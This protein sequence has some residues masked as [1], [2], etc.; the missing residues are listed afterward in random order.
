M[1]K[2][3]AFLATFAVLVFARFAVAQ[4]AAGNWYAETLDALVRINAT[5][6][7]EFDANWQR[8]VD[9]LETPARV[10]SVQDPDKGEI[11]NAE[12]SYARYGGVARSRGGTYSVSL[13]RRESLSESAMAQLMSSEECEQLLSECLLAVKGEGWSWEFVDY[14]DSPN[15]VRTYRLADKYLGRGIGSGL[16]VQQA[17][18]DR[19]IGVVTK[20]IFPAG[21]PSELCATGT[22]K[23]ASDLRQSAL[24]AYFAAQPFEHSFIGDGDL[25]Y[26][27]PDYRKVPNGMTSYHVDCVQNG[28]L[29][30]LYRMRVFASPD[31]KLLYQ[32]VYVD[33]FTGEPVAILSMNLGLSRGGGVGEASNTEWKPVEG[34]L[35]STDIFSVTAS[36]KADFT[37]GQAQDIP[38]HGDRVFLKS[39][40]QMIHAMYY[41]PNSQVLWMK[42]ANGISFAWSVSK[43]FARALV[44][45]VS[46]LRKAL[47]SL[48][49]SMKGG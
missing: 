32:H 13:Q 37:I 47:D 10:E 27:L 45:Q 18:V 49:L 33:A 20:L 6:D 1:K 39:S 22:P 42:Q 21:T 36:V 17:T 46:D 44:T 11:V 14:S 43:E 25:V 19:H 31:S 26:A 23:S 38:E 48:P 28:K 5:H 40:D 16:G 41:D 7:R 34:I 4:T 30:L 15:G 24:S 35:L 12:R 8:L 2:S 9:G 3:Q 29:T